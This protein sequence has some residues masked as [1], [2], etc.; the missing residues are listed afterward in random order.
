[1]SDAAIVT[2]DNARFS[3]E[4]VLDFT[5]VSRLA[6]EGMRLFAGHS[7]VDIDL[8]GVSAANSAGLVLLLEWMEL[9]RGRKLALRFL[10]LPRSLDRLAGL[11]NLSGILPVVRGGA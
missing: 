8:Q 9:A 11:A 1:M 5:T 3:V 4:G 6:A 7:R 2:K 10:N